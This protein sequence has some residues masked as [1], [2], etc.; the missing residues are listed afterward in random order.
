MKKYYECF[1]ENLFYFLKSKGIRYIR[2]YT[3]N[4]TKVKCHV[5][6]MTPEL[7][8]ALKEWSEN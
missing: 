5:Y 2:P 3:H 6:K 7:S 8:K 1:S 4:T